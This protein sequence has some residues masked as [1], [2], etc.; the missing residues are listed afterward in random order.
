[1]CYARLLLA[2]GSHSIATFKDSGA[3]V[4]II[5]EILALQLGISH[6]P[7]SCPILAN[8]LDG[9]LLGTVS[10][11]TT[12]V[13]MLISGRVKRD[14]RASVST[15]HLMSFEDELCDSLDYDEIISESEKLNPDLD[16]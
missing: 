10:H 13:S 2:D 12:P 6:V 5:D 15:T 9:H 7:L 8:A 4:N 16:L 3:D 11:Q 14:L 1:M